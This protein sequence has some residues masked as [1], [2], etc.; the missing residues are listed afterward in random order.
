[1]DTKKVLITSS[2]DPHAL[3][4]GYPRL[5][6]FSPQV[7]EYL[8]KKGYARTEAMLRQE[9]GNVDANGRVQVMRAE[10]QGGRKYSTAYCKSNNV[11]Q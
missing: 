8:S 1:M 3:A 10:D 9:S 6:I 4:R 2:F 7:I 11:I 5:T